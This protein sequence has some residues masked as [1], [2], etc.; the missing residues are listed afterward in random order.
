[1]DFLYHRKQYRIDESRTNYNSHSP[2]QGLRWGDGVE[3]RTSGDFDNCLN[4]SLEL[5]V[6]NKSS[7]LATQMT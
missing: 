2:S 5:L 3:R 4:F 7:R 6:V 1:M